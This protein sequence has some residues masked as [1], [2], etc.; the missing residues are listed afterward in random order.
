MRSAILLLGIAIAIGAPLASA[1]DGACA[2]TKLNPDFVPP[3]GF[4]LN[5][6]FYGTPGLWAYIVTTRWNLG[7]WHGNKLPY[8]SQYYDWKTEKQPHMTVEARRLDAPAPPVQ[9]ERVNGAGPS[10]LADEPVDLSKPGFMVTALHI[11]AA[12]C[13]EITA[14]YTPPSGKVETLSYTIVVEQ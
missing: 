3:P 13:W 8:F 4:E 9:S 11:P 2:V 12:G 1:A 14:R 5:G 6:N 10:H 7:D